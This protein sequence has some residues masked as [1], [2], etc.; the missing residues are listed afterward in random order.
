[1]EEVVGSIP[2]RSTNL[3][4]SPR[5]ANA[6]GM[7][8]RL[9]VGVRSWLGSLKHGRVCYAHALQGA[10]AM[11]LLPARAVLPTRTI[12]SLDGAT[13]QNHSRLPCDRDHIF[14]AGPCGSVKLLP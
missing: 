11:D 7:G 2:T 13:G 9:V 5:G 14:P 8:V 4:N 1:M 10:C 6:S 3:L 12:L